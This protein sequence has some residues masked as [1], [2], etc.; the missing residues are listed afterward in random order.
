MTSP[1]H[2]IRCGLQA[3]ARALDR[4]DGWTPEA[5]AGYGAASHALDDLPVV[6]AEN[7]TGPT[8]LETRSRKESHGKDVW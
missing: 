6:N 5:R 3:L 7:P 2:R 8:T 1:Q 4:A